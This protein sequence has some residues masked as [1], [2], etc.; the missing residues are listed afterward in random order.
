MT[1]AQT[2]KRVPSRSNPNC[3][4]THQEVFDLDR[5]TYVEDVYVWK[6][7]SSVLGREPSI[8]KAREG[9]NVLREGESSSVDCRAHRRNM[10][11]LSLPKGIWT[12]P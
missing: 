4:T 1:N 3:T 2:Y 11:G 12:P 10:V 5:G 6:W 7:R 9:N 8:C